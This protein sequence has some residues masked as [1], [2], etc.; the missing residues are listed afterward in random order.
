MFCISVMLSP[1]RRIL[2]GT[3]AQKD[4]SGRGEPREEDHMKRKGGS[5]VL[6]QSLPGLLLDVDLLSVVQNQVHVL[7][8]A[9]P[10]EVEMSKGRTEPSSKS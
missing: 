4:Q 10:R 2:P 1:L 8:E 5:L 3:G 6:T 7:V 9:L